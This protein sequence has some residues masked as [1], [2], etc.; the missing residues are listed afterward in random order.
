[1]RRNAK[2]AHRLQGLGARRARERDLLTHYQQVTESTT[3][4]DPPDATKSRRRFELEILAII[5][6]ALLLSF[7]VK[8]F[9]VQPFSIPSES[10]ESTLDIGDRIL[11]SKFTPQHSPLHRG[12]VVVFA[13][14][15]SWKDAAAPQ[16]TGIRAVIKSGLSWVGILPAGG[17]HYVVKR[18]IGMPGDHVVCDQNCF[19]RGGPLTVNGVAINEAGYL[20]PGNAP[21]A[22]GFDITVPQGSVWLMGDNRG[23]SGD[24]RAHDHGADGSSA[25]GTRGSVP[26][27][28]I[29]GEVVGIAWP[30]NHIQSVGS[31]PEVFAD[32]P[33]PPTARAH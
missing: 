8:T 33:A 2:P 20:N 28:D 5:V 9:I 25:D 14:P 3:A 27:S 24:S 23:H 17:Q 29:V 26:I 30:L 32:V 7:L 12:D 4:A 13:A 11:V 10:M 18:I 1:M 31:H 6:V 22:L 15:P 19:Q 21:S 16:S